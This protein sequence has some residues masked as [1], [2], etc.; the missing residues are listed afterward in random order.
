MRS[1]LALALAIGAASCE[2]EKPVPVVEGPPCPVLTAEAFGQRAGRLKTSEFPTFTLQRR[3]G[4]MACESFGEV[5]VCRLSAPGVLQV[6]A[7]Q[8]DWYFE[9]GVGRR[10][11]L[12]VEK[13]GPRCVLGA[14]ET[15]EDWAGRN[16]TRTY[17]KD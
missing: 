6:S 17:G 8:E 5:P 11:T 1:V 14:N 2:A 9:P 13:A 12:L 7:G 10:V 16:M 15:A 3:S 4:H